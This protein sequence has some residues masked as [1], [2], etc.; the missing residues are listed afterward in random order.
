MEKKYTV[1]VSSTYRDLLEQR[2]AVANTILELE[3]I[4]VGMRSEEHTS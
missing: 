4:P 2:K 3:H 1:F